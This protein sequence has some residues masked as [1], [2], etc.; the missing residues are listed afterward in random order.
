M[1]NTM[2]QV[3]LSPK[4]MNQ[5]NHILWS[6]KDMQ[7]IVGLSRTMTYQLLHRADVPVVVI[8]G[9]RFVDAEKFRE[10]MTKQNGN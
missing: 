9:R 7:E 4:V 3:V 2:N 6:A 8:G 5:M 10:W 1:E